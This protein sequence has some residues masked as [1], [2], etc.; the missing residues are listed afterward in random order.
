MQLIKTLER[1]LKPA[2]SAGSTG[3]GSGDSATEAVSILSSESIRRNS[4]IVYEVLD[5]CMV[6]WQHGSVRILETPV[7]DVK[8]RISIH[9]FLFL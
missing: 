9:F 6:T 5:E 2:S 1:F 3:T 4:G 8:K 7:L